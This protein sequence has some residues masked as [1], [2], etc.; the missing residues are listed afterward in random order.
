[1]PGATLTEGGNMPKDGLTRK[2]KAFCENYIANGGNA[3]QAAID[4]GYKPNSAKSVGSENL[5][6]PDIAAYIR[7]LSK[8]TEE[9]RIASAEEVLEYLTMVVDAK[10]KELRGEAAETVK[11]AD[12]NKA[13][14]LLG[15]FHQLY[16]ERIKVDDDSA[17]TIKVVDL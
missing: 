6:K 17:I 3:T 10:K 1:M 7:D 14:D 2:Q 9:K 16:V 5:S 4:A 15:K 8:P 11:T 12:A 13:A